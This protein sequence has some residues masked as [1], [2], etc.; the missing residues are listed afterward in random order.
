MSFDFVRSIIFYFIRSDIFG[1]LRYIFSRT[2]VYDLTLSLIIVVYHS[3]CTSLA[4]LAVD[5]SGINHIS[6]S[7]FSLF[8]YDFLYTK[9]LTI[10]RPSLSTVGYLI[11]FLQSIIACK[12]NCMRVSLIVYWWFNSAYHPMTQKSHQTSLGQLA[13]VIFCNEF[14]LPLAPQT[15][16]IIGKFHVHAKCLTD[17]LTLLLVEGMRVRVCSNVDNM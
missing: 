8:F 16:V 12:Q 5:S 13:I 3:D 1:I 4:S 17:E 7:P 6:S 14:C 9:Y 10:I 11:I 2:T 15:H